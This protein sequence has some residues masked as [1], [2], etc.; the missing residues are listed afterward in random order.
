MPDGFF[1]F[2]FLID[3]ESGK[4][5]FGKLTVQQKG[6]PENWGYDDVTEEFVEIELRS[7]RVRV[8]DRLAVGSRMDSLSTFLADRFHYKKGTVH[9]VTIGPYKSEFR[10]LSDTIHDI[11]IMRVCQN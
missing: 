11:R 1:G 5:P 7:N 3:R 8:W 10:V 9:V 2:Y 4:G 6:L